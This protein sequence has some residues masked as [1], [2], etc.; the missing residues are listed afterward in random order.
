MIIAIEGGDQAGK[1]TQSKMLARALKKHGHK[2]KL[3]HFPDYATPVGGEIKR[4]LAGRRE[5][6]PQ[7]IHCLLAANRWEK[8]GE[9]QRHQKDSI[10]VM[11]R[12]YQSNIVYG[13]ANG[14]NQKWL[15][16]LD[17]G[18]PRADLVILLDVE[19]GESFRRQ[20]FRRDRFEQDV[21]FS[22]KISATYKRLARKKRWKVIDASLPVRDIHE[23]VLKLSLGRL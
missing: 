3:F 7:L 11:N 14:L 15:E 16:N 20:R 6:A 4:Y 19:Q 18:L 21:A 17:A 2:T 13:M 8:L 10:L 5:F 22:K 9:I 12:Y 1:L 23:K